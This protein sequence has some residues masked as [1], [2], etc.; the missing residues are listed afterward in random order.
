MSLRREM[1]TWNAGLTSL[2]DE[3]LTSSCNT[4]SGLKNTLLGPILSY[5]LNSQLLGG[6]GTVSAFAFNQ[7]GAG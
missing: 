7:A 3:T 1:A 2:Q 6:R 5:F 4:A